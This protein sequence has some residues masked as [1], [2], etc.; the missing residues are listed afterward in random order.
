MAIDEL[1][2]MV[3]AALTINFPGTSTIDEWKDRPIPIRGINDDINHPK[4]VEMW[5]DLVMC[6]LNII[7]EDYPVVHASMNRQLSWWG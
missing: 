3:A 7:N 6:D 4:T 5:G 2:T 1:I